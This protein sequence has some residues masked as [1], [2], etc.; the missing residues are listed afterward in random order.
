MVVRVL[1]LIILFLLNS[2]LLLATGERVRINTDEV[3]TGVFRSSGGVYYCGTHIDGI[4]R[5]VDN[6]ASWTRHA[7]KSDPITIK[8]ASRIQTN[9]D[10]YIVVFIYDIERSAYTLFSSSDSCKTW[11]SI[12]PGY[13]SNQKAIKAVL[14]KNNKTIVLNARNSLYVLDSGASSLTP[15]S[16]LSGLTAQPV[17][18]SVSRDGN[19]FILMNDGTIE[20]MNSSDFE[21]TEKTEYI[22]VESDKPIKI[23][24]TEFGNFFA[25]TNNHYFYLLSSEKQPE[26]I[27]LRLPE[28]NEDYVF[29]IAS[30]GEDYFVAKLNCDLTDFNVF[31]TSYYRKSTKSNDE[32][33]ES[34]GTYGESTLDFYFSE[35]CMY[36]S[37][38]EYSNP[39]TGH[40]IYLIPYGATAAIN[41]DNAIVGELEFSFDSQINPSSIIL[42]RPCPAQPIVIQAYDEHGNALN[43]SG[44]FDSFSD[45]SI[46]MN[47]NG[48]VNGV[49]FIS[50]RSGATV[51]TKKFIKID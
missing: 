22:G 40:F 26:R 49:Y 2:L 37:V 44:L 28:R 6:G 27:P 31:E 39:L 25:F 32:F 9:D 29:E 3:I 30:A 48:L 19:I 45:S 7:S 16:A 14:L 42:T 43:N 23:Q 33:Y 34:P 41:D 11:K 15:I 5:S 35:N 21:H 12:L 24:V 20:K 8:C 13:E 47:C 51:S 46:G 18:F 10:K 36:L 38:T 4:L 1:I 17:D 50:L